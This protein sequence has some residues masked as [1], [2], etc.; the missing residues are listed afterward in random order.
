MLKAA[1]LAYRNGRKSYLKKE[2]QDESNRRNKNFQAEHPFMEKL[3]VWVQSECSFSGKDALI[4]S[5]L[6]QEDSISG[7]DLKEVSNC[8]KALGF[9]KD[10]VQTKVNGIKNIYK[11]DRGH[12]RHPKRSHK[13]GD[14]AFV[15]CL[16]ISGIRNQS[17]MAK[18]KKLNFLSKSSSSS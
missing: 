1:I 15:L 9:E 8:L 17:V 13:K 14:E 3:S 16:I 4:G 7:R 10:D 18:N 5:R 2:L 6:R 11:E 12:L